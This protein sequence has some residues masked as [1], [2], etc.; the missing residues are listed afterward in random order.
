MVEWLV[1]GV[2]YGLNSPLTIWISRRVYGWKI[3]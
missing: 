2:L 1:D 3:I